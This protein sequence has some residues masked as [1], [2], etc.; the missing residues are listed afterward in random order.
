MYKPEKIVVEVVGPVEYSVLCP[1]VVQT[2]IEFS[3]V[4]SIQFIADVLL[5]HGFDRKWPRGME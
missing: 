1:N 4:S 3:H 2:W 5:E